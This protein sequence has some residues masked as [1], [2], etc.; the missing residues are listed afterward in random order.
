LE[1]YTFHG[2]QYHNV[3]KGKANKYIYKEI[4]KQ[5][6]PIA[7][8]AATRYKYQ[9]ENGKRKVRPGQHWLLMWAADARG[10]HSGYKP[11]WV[12]L[13]DPLFWSKHQSRFFTVN[14]RRRV[15]RNELYNTLW[16]KIPA[17]G[18]RQLVED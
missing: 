6:R 2:F 16:L 15:Y 18:K 7:I 8:A 12:L 13:H 14:H 11:R 5:H 1:M 10:K 17:L 4:R 3:S 9:Y